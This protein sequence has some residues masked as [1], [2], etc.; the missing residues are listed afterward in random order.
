MV[1]WTVAALAWRALVSLP[2]NRLLDALPMPEGPEIRRAADRVASAIEGKVADK[3]FF[4]FERLK[5]FEKA[6]SG[7]RVREV[8]TC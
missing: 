2:R 4:A 6:L 7:R 1:T 5:T 8:T 3:V